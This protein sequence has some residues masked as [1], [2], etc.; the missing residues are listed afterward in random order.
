M[1]MIAL[2]FELIG[3]YGVYAVCLWAGLI[4]AVICG[5]M[6]AVFGNAHA[7]SPPTG[8]DGA[9]AGA[10]RQDQCTGGRGQCCR[11]QNHRHRASRRHHGVRQSRSRTEGEAEKKS[12][13][14]L[15]MVSKTR[16]RQ[17]QA[18]AHPRRRGK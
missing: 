3:F 2:G 14:T 5:V 13:P 1:T 9:D 4:F 11:H 12:P 10:L 7:D 18:A 16:F 8:G 6:S 17:R 15:M